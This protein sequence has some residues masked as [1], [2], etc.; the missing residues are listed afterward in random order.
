MIGKKLARRRRA[1]EA[2]KVRPDFLLRVAFVTLLGCT[3][4]AAFAAHKRKP[5]RAE[6]VLLYSPLHSERLR[7]R[8]YDGQGRPRRSA[9]RELSHFLRCPHTGAERP[10]DARLLPLVY[11]LGR[12]F[13][14]PLVVISGYRPPQ[15]ST[16][17]LSRH[18]TA[19]AIDFQ[20]PGVRNEEIV[21]WLRRQFHP[22]GI[23]FYPDGEHVHLDVDRSHD[24]FWVHHGSDHV[25]LASRRRG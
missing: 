7:L 22:V 5:P 11:A 13:Q 20:I 18:R 14:R 24:T 21:R 10:I 16:V 1:C 15:L 2:S 19:A 23:G 8:L 4:G 17:P 6:A 9:R 3:G 12:H 25:D